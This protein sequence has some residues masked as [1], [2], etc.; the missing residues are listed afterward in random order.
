VPWRVT[1]G[2]KAAS[3]VVEVLQ[4]RTKHVTDVAIE[5]VAEYLKSR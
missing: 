2:K 1:V 3:G 4:R 5:Q